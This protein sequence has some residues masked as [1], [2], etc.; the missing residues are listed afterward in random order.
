MVRIRLVA[1]MA[2]LGCGLLIS[3]CFLWPTSLGDASPELP[4]QSIL[5]TLAGLFMLIVVVFFV[6]LVVRRLMSG[7]TASV[8][9]EK[10]GVTGR[11]IE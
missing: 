11:S 7:P 2:I 8:P 3:T 4:K 1:I 5:S 9:P 10:P 6:V